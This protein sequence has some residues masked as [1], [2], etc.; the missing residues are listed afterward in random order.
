MGGGVTIYIYIYIYEIL[1]VSGCFFGV[2]YPLKFLY[3]LISLKKSID[4]AQRVC[5]PGFCVGLVA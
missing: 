1:F 5:L 4:I 2:P 3:G